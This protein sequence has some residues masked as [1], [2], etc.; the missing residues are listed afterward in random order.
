MH[1]WGKAKKPVYLWI[2]DR[3]IEMKSADHLW[4]LDTYQTYD[5]LQK[6]LG[7]KTVKISCIGPAGEKMVKFAL[8]DS[9]YHRHAGRCGTGAVM[10]SKNLKAI[11]VRG[12]GEISVADLKVFDK[13]VWDAYEEIKNSLSC[14][15][16]TKRGT[17]SVARFANVEGFFPA[18]NF[19]DGFFEKYRD[20]DDENQRKHLWLR[21][22]GCFACPIH[23]SKIGMIRRG[24]YRGEICDIIEYE[25]I[26]LLGGSCGIEY[27]EGLAYA[28][29]L[30]DKLGLDTIST[31]NVIGFAMECYEMGILDKKDTDGL[32]LKFGNWETQIELIRRIAHREGLGDILAEGVMRASQRIG[33]GS[34]DLA[35]HIKGMEAPAW[36]LQKAKSSLAHR[37]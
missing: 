3:N 23:C 17:P 10:G 4:G 25:T 1:A 7:D 2:N 6:E 15:Q 26:G 12:S 27:L 13:A 36:D 37:L 32:E 5:I 9:Y 14:Q 19:R 24:P 35:V 21:E 34:E 18:R 28:N 16:Y 29:L 30:C 8:V 31:G 20:L 11:A 22:Y 33:K